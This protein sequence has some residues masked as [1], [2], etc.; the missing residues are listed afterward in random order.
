MVLVDSIYSIAGTAYGGRVDGDPFKI[1]LFGVIPVQAAGCTHP[2][3]LFGV[4]KKGDDIIIGKGRGIAKIVFVQ[5]E[6]VTV[7]PVEPV[8]VA[9]PY[10]TAAVLPNG[11][12]IILR[13]TVLYVQVIKKGGLG[14]TPAGKTKKPNDKSSQNSTHDS[15]SCG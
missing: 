15:D 14:L 9:I 10:K 12:D 13:E 1:V 11:D 2:K 4:A 7:I 3:H 5:P 6:A 8:L